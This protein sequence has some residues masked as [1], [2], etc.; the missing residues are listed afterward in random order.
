VAGV[1]VSYVGEF[2]VGTLI[3]LD[4]DSLELLEMQAAAVPVKM[5]YVPILLSSRELPPAMEVIRKLELQPDIFL[6]DT[7]G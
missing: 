2:S 3:F 6:V 7:Q 4:Y 5:P 1:R